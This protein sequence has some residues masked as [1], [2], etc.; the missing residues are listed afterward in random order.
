MSAQLTQG[1]QA[2]IHEAPT[3]FTPPT[4][5]HVVAPAAVMRFV[6]VCGSDAESVGTQMDRLVP[7]QMSE[8]LTQ[9]FAAETEPPCRAN[10]V[11]IEELPLTS[12]YRLNKMNWYV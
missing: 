4:A 2:L 9:G 5:E 12:K 7:V 11:S 1:F 6:H 10:L 8:Q 3:P